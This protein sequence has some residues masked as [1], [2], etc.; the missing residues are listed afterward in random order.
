MACVRGKC[1][2]WPQAEPFDAAEMDLLH[3]VRA[4]LKSP[5]NVRLWA[6]IQTQSAAVRRHRLAYVL[7]AL[8]TNGS[9]PYHTTLLWTVRNDTAKVQWLLNV[10]V[11]PNIMASLPSSTGWK[12]G[13]V[14]PGRPASTYGPLEC[15]GD[16]VVG[17][18]LTAGAYPRDT[19]EAGMNASDLA[20]TLQ[21]Q[22]HAWHARGSR[23]VWSAT[24]L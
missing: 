18:F 13:A 23:R 14:H 9:S 12:G 17:L 6:N 22:W 20:L 24:M 10:G 2:C 19:Y 3:S 16:D 4:H 11:C 5:L 21:R 1:P 8:I 15:C 7:S